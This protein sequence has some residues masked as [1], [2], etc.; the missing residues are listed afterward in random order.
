MLQ[1]RCGWGIKMR[2]IVINHFALKLTLARNRKYSMSKSSSPA[3]QYKAAFSMK[4]HT[5]AKHAA[6]HM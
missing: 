2:Q 1:I 4:Q 6:L 5:I 3:F